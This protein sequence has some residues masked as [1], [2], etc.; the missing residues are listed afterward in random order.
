MT[1]YRNESIA[2]ANDGI[3]SGGMAG[4][5]EAPIQR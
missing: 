1:Q 5:V 4:P 3:A 2:I